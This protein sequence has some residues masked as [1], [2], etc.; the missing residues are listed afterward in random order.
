MT[1]NRIVIPEET[2]IFICIPTAS[3]LLDVFFIPEG[4]VHGQFFVNKRWYE[5]TI[6]GESVTAKPGPLS[7]ERWRSD[8]RGSVRRLSTKDD[9]T[10]VWWIDGPDQPF[11]YLAMTAAN[12]KAIE[13]CRAVAGLMIPATRPVG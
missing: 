9:H 1:R 2:Q 7:H 3:K 6:D 8:L 10:Y 11:T 5:L 12:R 4:M 13:A